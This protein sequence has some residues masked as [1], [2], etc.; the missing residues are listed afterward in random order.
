[1]PATATVGQRIASHGAGRPSAVNALVWE[2]FVD[3][4]IVAL[5]E[6]ETAII[7]GKSPV[8]H[9]N[10]PTW[11]RTSRQ[12][13]GKHIV[14]VPSEDSV[15]DVLV[16]T[17]EMIKAASLDD[18]FL[19]IQQISFSDQQKRRSQS[20]VGR[21]AYST[22]IR[23]VSGLVADLDLRIEAK[24][25]LG[26]NDAT[27][28]CGPDGALRFGDPVNPYT[29]AP[30]GMMLAYAVRHDAAKWRLDIE[31]KLV[32]F[33]A[34][35]SADDILAGGETLLASDLEV[36]DRPVTVVHL[37]LCLETDPS[38]RNLDKSK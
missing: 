23:V 10:M 8:D 3:R 35:N 21:G 38:I 12:T 5:R 34:I 32:G 20:R 1:M 6:A 25:M 36:G 29:D 9:L 37:T 17:L 13:F 28:Y 27:A 30:I 11:W 14:K 18:D 24:I 15:T 16:R 31:R 7:T 26:G 2:Q 22:D 4:I 33:D 19:R